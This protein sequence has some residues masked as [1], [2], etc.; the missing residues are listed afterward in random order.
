MAT[1]PR[2]APEGQRRC[3]G[4]HWLAALQSDVRPQHG[5]GWKMAGG[6]GI[7]LP[8]CQTGSISS[9]PGP[10]LGRTE[11]HALRRN[12]FQAPTSVLEAINRRLSRHRRPPGH[13]Y[14]LIGRWEAARM[15]AALV[16]LPVSAT[17]ATYLTRR[18]PS[19]ACTSG[20]SPGCAISPGPDAQPRCLPSTHHCA[21]GT[22]Q[23]PARSYLN[24]LPSP[25][26]TTK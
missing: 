17:T 3:I 5:T 11:E 15:R 19:P 4:L 12:I 22:L 13:A 18:P 6:I 2:H 16:T 14:P 26:T 25:S 8:S 10:G 1:T 20:H 9:A 21:P 23:T 7:V 24:P